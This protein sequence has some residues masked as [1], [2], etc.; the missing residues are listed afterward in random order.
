[1]RGVLVETYTKTEHSKT[2]AEAWRSDFLAVVD[3]DLRTD[4]GANQVL[5]DE[6]FRAVLAAID[7][8][9]YGLRNYRALVKRSEQTIDE[10]RTR[11]DKVKGP[12]KTLAWILVAL[13]G[14]AA[15]AAL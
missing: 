6:A 12:V 11:S 8:A 2:E 4:L 14:L 15:L 1:M 10:L 5:R 13:V 9:A 3:V 7:K